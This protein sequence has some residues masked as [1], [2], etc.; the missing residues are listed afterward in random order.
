MKSEKRESKLRL[1]TYYN[2][3]TNKGRVLDVVIMDQHGRIF[4]T[5]VN[6]KGK[7]DHRPTGECGSAN[8]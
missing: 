1:K 5:F 4:E 3:Y 7:T 2:V 6:D 8:H